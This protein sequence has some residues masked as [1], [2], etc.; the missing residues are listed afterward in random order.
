MT[1]MDVKSVLDTSHPHHH[2]QQQQ[3]IMSSLPMSPMSPCT[4]SNTPSLLCDETLDV[5][6][7]HKTPPSND[8]QAHLQAQ[9][10]HGL[11]N[12]PDSMPQTVKA[13]HDQ[14]QLNDARV[15]QNLL[16]NEHRFSPEVKDYMRTIQNEITPHMRKLVAD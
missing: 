12:Y 15:L 11:N 2:H 6:E 16:R 10:Q 14:S 13:L 8:I 1:N 4:S 9:H 7:L 3:R 5:N